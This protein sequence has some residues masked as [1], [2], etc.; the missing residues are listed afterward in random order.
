[1]PKTLPASW[2]EEQS[3]LS[4]IE[5]ALA[6]ELPTKRWFGGKDQTISSVDI[7]TFFPIE[8]VASFPFALVQVRVSF[9]EGGTQLYALPIAAFE[10]KDELLGD[11]LAE[12]NG[13]YFADIVG[14]A[15]FAGTVLSLLKGNTVLET[16]EGASLSFAVTERGE[17]LIER[18][19]DGDVRLLGVEQSNSSIVIDSALMLKM[20][21]KTEGGTHPEVEIGH[22]LTENQ[23]FANMPPYLG[24]ITFKAADGTETA[25]AALQGFVPNEGDGWEDALSMLK[26]LFKSVEKSE[27]APADLPAFIRGVERLGQ[28]TAEMHKAFDGGETAAFKPE[29]MTKKDL[30]ALTAQ[31]HGQADRTKAAMEKG[32]PALTGAAEKQV[33]DILAAWEKVTSQIDAFIPKTA[34][35]TKTRVHGDYHLGQVLVADRDYYLLDFEGEPLR[36]LSERRAKQSPFKDV[37][38]MLRS[39]NY[40]AWAALFEY[41]DGDAT[42][43]NLLKETAEQWEKDV[44]EA[45]MTGYRKAIAGASSW[46]TNAEEEEAFLNLF[47]LEKALYEVIY[48]VANRPDWLRIPLQGVLRLLKS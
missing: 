20:Y 38:G 27:D 22:F 46:P 40:A 35:V 8:V 23:P 16:K 9:E 37:A 29:P 21:R 31:V 1:M 34:T 4:Q 39:F 44:V 12:A 19:K 28:R 32:L 42:K 15:L 26:R 6:S 48:E 43:A 47:V 10:K 24:N 25:M 17:G 13:I 2:G 36:C 3:L 41:T 18:H 33:T 11:Y 30:D 45:F 5:K 14:E 7:L